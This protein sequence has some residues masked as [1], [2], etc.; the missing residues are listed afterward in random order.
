M[1]FASLNISVNILFITA[2]TE[3]YFL[4]LLLERNYRFYVHAGLR[5]ENQDIFK[6]I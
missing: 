6:R 5:D 4:D 1:L 2:L 3:S